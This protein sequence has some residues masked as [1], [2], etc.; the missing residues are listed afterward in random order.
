MITDK[1]L[2]ELAVSLLLA[3]HPH[4]DAGAPKPGSLEWQH[5]VQVVVGHLA[6]MRDNGVPLPPVIVADEQARAASAW[7][8]EKCRQD[9]Q[10]RVVEAAE[11]AAKEGQ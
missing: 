6:W 11:R 2:V 4:D 8:L 3:T 7:L 10:A 1:E 9:A 5:A